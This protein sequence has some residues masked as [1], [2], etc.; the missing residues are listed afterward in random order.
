MSRET[1]V[2]PGD[3]APG[4]ALEAHTGE[5]VGLDGF[6]GSRSVALYFMRAFT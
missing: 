6:R 5:R 4:F 1:L 2:S 3:E